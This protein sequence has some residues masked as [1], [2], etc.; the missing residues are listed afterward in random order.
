MTQTELIARLAECKTWKT[1]L[2]PALA[3]AEKMGNPQ[4]NL[5]FVHV[6]GTNGKGSTCAMTASILEKAGYKVGRFISPY[7]LEFRERIEINGEMI[8][9]EDLCRIGEEVLN[10]AAALAEEDIHPTEF[11][12][13]TVI[14]M[15]WFAEQ[16]CDIV[17]LEVGLGGT[18][19]STNIVTAET[20]LAT[21]IT[22]VSIDHAAILGETEEKIAAEKSG[23]IK[24]GGS[25]VLGKSIP[26]AALNLIKRVAMKKNNDAYMANAAEVIM[27]KSHTAGLTFWYKGRDYDLT[28]P[29][30]YQLQN[31]VVALRI[32]EVL[33]RKGWTI[34]EDHVADGL[35]HV[36]FP[37]RMELMG[38]E[39][40][41]WIDGA[42]NQEGVA[43][44][45]FSLSNLVP[46][47]KKVCIH[48]MMQDK[49]CEGVVEMLSGAFD[50]VITV[51]PSNPRAVKAA[52][53]A[54]MWKKHDAEVTTAESVEAAIAKAVEMAGKDGAVVCCGSLFLC[55]D[56]RP[57]AM[58]F[59]AEEK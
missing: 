49:D 43:A 31:A 57:H 8:P 47:K 2:T 46:H 1:D 41:F 30:L 7:V 10:A 55:A 27:K 48:G 20:V 13:V 6:G 53:L 11:D 59:F 56:A 26:R 52:D 29:G 34:T 32:V 19:D 37:A 25:L 58:A 22:S 36:H 28:L 54:E 51:E 17:V 40:L 38:K 44:L 35:A 16:K 18:I 9:E 42:H 14:G 39:P 3:L 15:L 33:R 4:N 21:A 45:L 24:E 23:I 12:V 50:A 5:K